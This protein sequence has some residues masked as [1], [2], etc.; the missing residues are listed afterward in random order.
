MKTTRR[1]SLGLSLVVPLLVI[2]CSTARPTPDVASD[3]DGPPPWFDPRIDSL[4]SSELRRFRGAAEFEEYRR[5]LYE[6]A[7]RF[8]ASWA[9]ALPSATTELVASIGGVGAEPLCDPALAECGSAL[10]EISVTGSRVAA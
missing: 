1:L 6:L 4:A 2:S 5:H 10:E 8:D 3:E 7:V 9:R